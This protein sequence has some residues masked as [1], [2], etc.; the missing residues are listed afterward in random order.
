MPLSENRGTFGADQHIE[1]RVIVRRLRE[2]KRPGKKEGPYMDLQQ[3]LTAHHEIG[4]CSPAA[5]WP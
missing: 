2:A 1:V 4:P 5:M 3:E